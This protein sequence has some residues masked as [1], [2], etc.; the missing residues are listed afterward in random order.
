MGAWEQHHLEVPL[1]D[2]EICCCLVQIL[3]LPN[4]ESTTISR[5]IAAF[6]EGIPTNFAH[7]QKCNK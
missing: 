4:C 5:A 1:S 7:M 6:Q 2:L 3:K